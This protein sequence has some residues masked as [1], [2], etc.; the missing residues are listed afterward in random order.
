MNF[1]H[2]PQDEHTPAMCKEAYDCPHCGA[3]AKQLWSPMAAG[4][5]WTRSPEAVSFVRGPQGLSEIDHT[6][7]RQICGTQRIQI[8]LAKC[9]IRRCGKLSLWVGGEMVVPRTLS[10]PRPHEDMKG[11]ARE[12]YEE[13]RSIA[14]A[15]PKSAAVLLRR[16]V[17]VALDKIA[18]RKKGET[19]AGLLKRLRDEGKIRRSTYEAADTLRCGGNNGAH[20]IGQIDFKERPEVP[21]GLMELLNRMYQELIAQPRADEAFRKSMPPITQGKNQSEKDKGRRGS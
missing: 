4:H 15:S 5:G 17:E 12:L 6:S 10:G 21:A 14:D 13:A 7:L 11:E 8:W 20:P 18:K 2:T 3:Y 9:T 19:L 16:T 1:D